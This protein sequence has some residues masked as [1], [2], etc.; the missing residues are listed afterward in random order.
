MDKKKYEI[1]L[2]K[3]I[4]IKEAKEQIKKILSF[5]EKNK[6]LKTVPPILLNIALE[7]CELNYKNKLAEIYTEALYDIGCI[8][9]N[10]LIIWDRHDLSIK[11]LDIESLDNYF[12]KAVGGVLYIQSIDIF[13]SKEIASVLGRYIEKYNGKVVVIL[14]GQKRQMT[15][16]IKYFGFSELVHFVVY[17]KDF[18]RAD[19]KK[20]ILSLLNNMEYKYELSDDVLNKI[21]DFAD[22]VRKNWRETNTLFASI[23]LRHIIEQQNFRT[24]KKKSNKITSDDIKILYQL[25]SPR[26]KRKEIVYKKV[27]ADTKQLYF[28][29]DRCS[30]KSI[31]N[32]EDRNVLKNIMEQAIVDINGDCTGCIITDTGLC[33]TCGHCVEGDE[34]DRNVRV[35]FYLNNGKMVETKMK[36]KVIHATPRDDNDFALIQL[37][38]ENKSKRQ[39]FVYIPLEEYENAYIEKLQEF[40]SAG[41]PMGGDDYK[42][43]SMVEGKVASIQKE[44][45]YLIGWASMLSLPGSSGSPL[46]DVDTGKV[47]GTHQSALGL[48]DKP[49]SIKCF[50]PVGEIW[51]ELHRFFGIEN[52]P[53]RAKRKI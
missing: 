33:I 39:N 47:I 8:K 1:E 36:Y 20:Y 48:R 35:K 34:E 43:L 21:L 14:S 22:N 29:I 7:G 46:I 6:D 12:E 37:Y 13:G 42:S 31:K 28:D 10:K 41:Y 24:Y 38:D 27:S 53:R 52:Q 2:D 16:F 18:N 40:I 19:L 9:E 51:R 17:L 26:Q 4:G 50:L 49:D 30:K 23:I 5:A 25:F 45:K 3:I 32:F 11:R 44:G 15:E